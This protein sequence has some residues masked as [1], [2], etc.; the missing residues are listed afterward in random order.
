MLVLFRWWFS[1]VSGRVMLLWW[2]VSFCVWVRVWLVISSCCILFLF[3]CCVVSLMVLLVLISSMVE[4]FSWVNVFCVRCMVVE[5]IDIGLVLIWV[6]VCVCLV[7]EKVCWNRWFR[8]CLSSLWLC[9]V[10]QVF[11]IWLRI[12]GLFSIIEFSLVVIWNRWCIVLVLVC[13]YRQFCRLLVWLC[14]YWFSVCVELV[15]VYSL[16]WLQVD[17]R[18]VLVICG[19]LC[20]E[21]SVCGNVLLVKV[22]CLCSFIG[23]VW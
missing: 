11:F 2:L 15:M 8:C 20:S 22:V 14:S 21:F 12:C 3:R 10:D 9:V 16:V 13:W 5:V 7:I 17:S 18:I 23:V 4:L 19:V 1:L 6:L